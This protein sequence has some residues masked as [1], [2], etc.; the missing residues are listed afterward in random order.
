MNNRNV[1]VKIEY[2]S[3]VL[4]EGVFWDDHNDYIEDISN[5]VAKVAAEQAVK[6]SSSVKLGMWTAT[7]YIKIDDLE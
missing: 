6:L 3:D 1:Y 7:P 4:G 2:K 5:S